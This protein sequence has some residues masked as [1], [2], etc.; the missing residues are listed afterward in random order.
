MLITPI[1]SAATKKKPE[2][3]TET[4]VPGR[5]TGDTPYDEPNPGNE[6]RTVHKAG[7]K[8]GSEQVKLRQAD[9]A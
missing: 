3:R 9:L 1:G 8:A 6:N 5:G 7:R 2:N 4:G